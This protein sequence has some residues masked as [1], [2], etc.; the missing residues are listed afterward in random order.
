MPQYLKA[1]IIIL[2]IAVIMF[3]MIELF[4]IIK[5]ILK[6]RNHKKMFDDCINAFNQ[7][8]SK[9]DKLEIVS[10]KHYDL[11]LKTMHTKYFIK[12]YYLDSDGDIYITHENKWYFR[13][14]LKPD[15]KIA[16]KE[17]EE[18]SKEDFSDNEKRVVKIIII[19]PKCKQLIY[20]VNEIEQQ[21][22]TS[23]KD[24][25]GCHIYTYNSLLEQLHI[26]KEEL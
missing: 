24:V 8:I 13:K 5:T 17:I 9:Q 7:I 23:N 20:D 16:L 18:F 19:Y 10:G 26:L 14:Y 4:L 2:S 1:I 22:V 12:L 6:K 3:L 25:F 11:Y 21:F 15:S